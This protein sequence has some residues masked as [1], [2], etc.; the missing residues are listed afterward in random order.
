MPDTLAQIA[1]ERLRIKKD[2]DESLAIIEDEEYTAVS[3]M[4]DSIRARRHTAETS[5]LAIITSLK[6]QLD[7]ATNPNAKKQIQNKIEKTQKQNS[8]DLKALEGI[9]TKD[10]S[11]TKQPFIQRRLALKSWYDTAVL[12]LAIREKA[13]E[14]ARKTKEKEV[15]KELLIT[16]TPYPKW[17]K[18]LI[19]GG[20]D[21]TGNGTQV[22]VSGRGTRD[23]FVATI[24]L[25]V[26]GETNIS[27]GF[28]GSAGSGSMYFGGGTQPGGI[29][30]SMSD[31]PAP[32]G[33]GGF[34]VAA[35]G[36]D[37][38]DPPHIGGFAVCFS[39]ADIRPT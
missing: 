19:V 6:N 18:D 11:D 27:F 31:S 34:S 7:A 16:R 26:S 21:I 20:I 2:Y 13:Y 39:E 25:V 38:D 32:C 36:G 17:W 24:V 29:V 33:R 12:S 22:V 14:E 9:W 1:I 4:Q 35:S 15:P 30:I 10:L 8:I 37:P 3:R 23:L 5:A 28:G